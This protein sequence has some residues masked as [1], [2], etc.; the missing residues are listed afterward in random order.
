MERELTGIAA[1]TGRLTEAV[2]AGGTALAPLLEKLGQEATRRETLERETCVPRRPRERGRLGLHGGTPSATSTSE[3]D[4]TGALH[5]SAGCPDVLA[6]FVPTIRFTPC[7]SG[8]ARGYNFHERG[9]YGALCGETR[10]PDWCPRRDSMSRA[11]GPAP[12]LSPYRLCLPRPP[13]PDHAAKVASLSLPV[14][15][16]GDSSAP[17]HTA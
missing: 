2:A 11:P 9:D 15:A 4:S 10:R 8:R 6:A 7:G 13:S 5:A 17:V 14:H 1:R 3:P 16:S 12:E